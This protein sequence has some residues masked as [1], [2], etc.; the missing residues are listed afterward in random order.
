MNRTFHVKISGTTRLFLVAFTLMMLAAFWYKGAA[1]IGLLFALIVIINIERIIHSAYTLTADGRLVVY[2]GRFQKG[3]TLPLSRITDV[4]LKRLFGWKHLMLSRYVLVY[5]DNDKVLDLF[6]EKPEEF[7]R[8]LVM[9][10]EHK[11]EEED[12]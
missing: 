7:M 6:P 11:V 3:K 1:L 9:R 8:A 4:Q 10:L 5:Y 2:N 12:E